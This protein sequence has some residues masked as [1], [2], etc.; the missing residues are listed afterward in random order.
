M[1]S[2]LAFALSTL[3]VSGGA[4]LTPARADNWGCSYE[5]CLASCGKAGGRVGLC[6]T[7]CTKRLSEKQREKV[8]KT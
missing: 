2:F 5:K 1:R 3:I 4:G 7:Y 8:C 6:P